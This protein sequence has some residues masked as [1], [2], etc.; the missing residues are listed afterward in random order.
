MEKVYNI[1]LEHKNK[2]RVRKKELKNLMNN[3]NLVNNQN[4]LINS[5]KKKSI[6]KKLSKLFYF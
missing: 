5:N 1:L 2:I 6:S 4:Y 3:K